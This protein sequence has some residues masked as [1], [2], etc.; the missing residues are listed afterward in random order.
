[1]RQPDDT[2]DFTW[3]FVTSTDYELPL[4]ISVQRQPH[5]VAQ[6]SAHTSRLPFP[7]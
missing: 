4:L 6:P 3:G 7:L 5:C 2:A 1:M